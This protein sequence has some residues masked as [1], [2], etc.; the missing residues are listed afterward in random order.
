M[1]D[2]AGP[3]FS[4]ERDI[5]AV[6]SIVSELDPPALRARIDTYLVDRSMG[7][8]R[9]VRHAAAPDTVTIPASALDNRVVGVQLIYEGLALMRALARE[10]AWADGDTDTSNLDLLVAEVLVAKGF[11]LLAATAAAQTAVETVRTLGRTETVRREQDGMEAVRPS[12]EAD[13]FE[14]GVVAGQSATG[15]TADVETVA[16]QVVD[17]LAVTDDLEARAFAIQWQREHSPTHE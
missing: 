9:L 3:V 6:T 4:V 15:S 11:S 2:R 14:L 12:L 8:G 17:R 16:R 13:V 10:P 1:K 7:A 5:E